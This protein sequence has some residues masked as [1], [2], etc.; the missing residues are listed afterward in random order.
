MILLKFSTIA[1]E[2]SGVNPLMPTGWEV[3]A[4]VASLLA[5]GLFIAALYS[6][7]RQS[8]NLSG[9]TTLG[10]AVLIVFLPLAGP[11]LWFAMVFRWRK[12]R[13]LNTTTRA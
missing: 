13:P 5:I 4:T 7:V 8:K 3:L 2:V 10:W 11:I 6:L 1:A 12:P 9:S